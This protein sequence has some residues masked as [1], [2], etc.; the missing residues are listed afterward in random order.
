[1]SLLYR[2]GY[3]LVIASNQSGLGRGLFD[4]Y[5]L[6]QIHHKLCYMVEE[7]GGLVDGIYY[8]PHL[9]EDHCDCR[10]PATGMLK[11]IEQN[12]DCSVKEP[13]GDRE[14]RS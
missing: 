11:R 5:I 12:L 3:K 10:K 1:M 6:N 8:C 13:V 7:L 2:S 9:P 4:E 14:L